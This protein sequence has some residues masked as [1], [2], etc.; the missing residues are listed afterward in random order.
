MCN[1]LSQGSVCSEFDRSCTIK[2]FGYS[3]VAEYYED[4]NNADRLRLVKRPMIC[5][6]AED[7]PFAPQ[8]S[9][10]LYIHTSIEISFKK[11]LVI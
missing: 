11:I 6:Q 1:V 2:V 8:K 9:V 7:D 10:L 4:I 3:S 5:I